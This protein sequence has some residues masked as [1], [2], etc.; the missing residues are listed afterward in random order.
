VVIEG[1]A[2]LGVTVACWFREKGVRWGFFDAVQPRWGW[3]GDAVGGEGL[4]L[5]AADWRLGGVGIV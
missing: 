2:W 5:F 3:C 1:A 4:G